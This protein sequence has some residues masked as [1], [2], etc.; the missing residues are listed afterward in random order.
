[1][2]HVVFV[3]SGPA[4]LGAFAAA[5]EL[6]HRVTFVEGRDISLLAA[7]ATSPE[8]VAAALE[9]V[10]RHVVLDALEADLDAA[11]GRIHAEEPVDAVLTTS[12]LVVLPTA[13]A[14]ES[15]GARTTPADCLAQAVHK[16][17]CRDRL[18]AAGIRSPR[19]T[20]VTTA[21][22]ARAA[23]RELGLPMVLKPSRGVGKEAAA[24]VRSDA[25]L[26][27][28]FTALEERRAARGDTV[29]G[30]FVS[31]EL[32][33]EGYLDG[34]LYSAEVVAGG[35][36]PRVL[37][38]TRRERATHNELFEVAAVMPAGLTQDQEADVDEYM[39]EVFGELGLT[40]GA[41]HV[42]FI[43]TARGPAL[44]EINA[45]MMGGSSPV[46]FR[47]VTGADPFRILVEE[48]LGTHRALPVPPFGRA[49]IVVVFGAVE[50]GV[51][52]P[53]V[54]ER[55]ERVRDKYRP[56][57]HA[58]GVRGG[59][60]VTPMTGNFTVLGSSCLDAATTEEAL[61]RGRELLDD[62]EDAL[63]VRLARYA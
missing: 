52:P 46:I 41:Y 55:V 61:A 18:R 5:R 23:C 20:T 25:E 19:H 58:L 12:E 63:Q 54:A 56:L 38:T 14:A 50:D 21:E 27:A 45:R 33:A 53:D 3:D 16:D 34:G 40:V 30:R 59:R 37:M 17:V 36:S 44:V 39:K 7:T 28:H 32:V 60:P 51:T 2:A 11:I 9:H 62:M 35:G 8:R 24:I 57:S 48:H 6:G 15:I 42:E 26:A 22:Q 47:H 31:T 49:G 1:M 4:Y 13:R 29:L 10:D 43:M